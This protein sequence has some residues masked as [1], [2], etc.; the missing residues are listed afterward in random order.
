M[1]KLI[2]KQKIDGYSDL[3]D[4]V[5]E[6]HETVVF[7]LRDISDT[8]PRR[9][10]SK[11]RPNPQGIYLPGYV[12]P[13]LNFEQF[14]YLDGK[15]LEAFAGG[16][17]SLIRDYQSFLNAKHE[18]ITTLSSDEGIF[19]SHRKLPLELRKAF[20]P[21]SPISFSGVHLSAIEIFEV[22]A[23]MLKNPYR[24]IATN[25][26]SYSQDRGNFL[27]SL[28]QDSGFC[29]TLPSKVAQS[30]HGFIGKDTFATYS[31]NRN[32]ATITINKGN[33]IRLIEYY[34][35]RFEERD[36]ID[37]IIDPVLS[38]TNFKQRIP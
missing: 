15:Y 13:A 1:S 11:I 28:A 32:N 30:L 4:V 8:I 10:L 25:M 9:H 16:T 36:S 7:N 34:R 18:Y 26:S 37:K 20:S 33:D 31:V 17:P 38:I 5:A 27:S 2:A 19:V 14:S 23:A 6:I 24:Q 12:D 35:A 29:V 21:V 3:T 22:L